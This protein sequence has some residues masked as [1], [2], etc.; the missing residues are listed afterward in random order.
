MNDLMDL[1]MVKRLTN[2]ASNVLQ[3][4]DGEAIF[5]SESG[6]N[7]VALN[8]LG[9]REQLAVL[10]ADSV[11]RGNV[12]A[13]EDLCLFGLVKDVFDQGFAVF[14]RQLYESNNFESDGL[15]VFT[16]QRLVDGRGRL[17]DLADN[18]ETPD[19]VGHFLSAPPQA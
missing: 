6:C 4:P 9:G 7:R 3:V 5:T 11:E 8:V 12:V 10:I 2:L 16:V 14:L 17:R 15:L 13:A 1:R 18:F 19:Y